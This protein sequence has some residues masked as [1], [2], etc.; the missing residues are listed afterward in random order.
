LLLQLLRDA[1][2]VRHR[3]VQ[4]HAIRETPDRFEALA[5]SDARAA[6]DARIVV[7]NSPVPAS[8]KYVPCTRSV[9]LLMLCLSC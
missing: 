7:Q 5:S 4:G 9:G 3:G 2:H 1:L 6:I 8:A